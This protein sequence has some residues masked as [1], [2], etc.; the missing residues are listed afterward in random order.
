MF[1]TFLLYLPAGPRI[2]TSN[3]RFLNRN[4]PSTEGVNAC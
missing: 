3:L 2:L 1:S 4:R